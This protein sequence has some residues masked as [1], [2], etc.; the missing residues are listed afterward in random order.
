MSYLAYIIIFTCIIGIINSCI[1]LYAMRMHPLVFDSP[2]SN[3]NI[4]SNKVFINTAAFYSLYKEQVNCISDNIVVIT[5]AF[6]FLWLLN[7]GSL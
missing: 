1:K 2:T 7:G 6:I 5:G 3:L 4:Y